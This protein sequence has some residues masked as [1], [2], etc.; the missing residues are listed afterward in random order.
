MQGVNYN[1]TGKTST[2]NF[3]NEAYT[4]GAGSISK[5]KAVTLTSAYKS[6]GTAYDADENTVVYAEATKG[7]SVK[8]GTTTTTIVGGSGKDSLV[9]TA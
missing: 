2:V 9:A 5:D 7:V 4:V 6:N 1:E 8:G 3:N